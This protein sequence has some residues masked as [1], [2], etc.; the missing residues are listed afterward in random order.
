[1]NP[2][3]PSRTEVA[4]YTAADARFFP[5][6]VALL[7]SL[8]LRGED[9][10]LFV[11]DCGL[12]RRQRER[13]SAHTTL[14]PT[15]ESLHPSCQK[16]TGPLS[17]PAELMV[18]VD[19]D[20][21]LTRSLAPLFEDARMGNI[22]GFEDKFFRDR[23]FEEWSLLGF[24][25]PAKRRYANAG[26]LIFSETTADELLP[27][28]VELQEQLLVDPSRAHYGGA[29]RSSGHSNPFYFADQDIL[30]ALFSTRFDGRVVTLDHRLAPVPPFE[31]LEVPDDDPL[32]CSYADAVRPFALHHIMDKPWLSPIEPNAYSEI[33]RRVVTAP[34][35]PIR[36]DGR[37][38]PLRL[39][40]SRLAP[41]ARWW[42]AARLGLHRHLRGRLG[43]RP[44]I[45]RWLSQLRR[46]T[47]EPS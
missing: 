8:R 40:D 11:V 20:I 17:Y 1:M 37:D 36:L 22:V 33:L 43:L 12:T 21:I 14:I 32:S 10:P 42:L 47:H 23:T 41:V 9:A 5:G 28:F 18:V 15:N 29:P 2:P 30:N 13:L 31:G 19:S 4:Y 46:Q 16:A 3:A 27:T 38:I 34:A 26:L 44:V 24:G 35:A 7:N 39:T 25:A 6:V 45:A